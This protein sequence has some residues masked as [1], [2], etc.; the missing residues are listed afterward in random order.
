[1]GELFFLPAL[2]GSPWCQVV[3][4]F[5]D[6]WSPLLV[7]I[8]WVRCHV[9]RGSFGTFLCLRNVLCF[10][11]ILSSQCTETHRIYTGNQCCVPPLE[12]TEDIYKFVYRDELNTCSKTF[13]YIY[14]IQLAD[15]VIW[16][17]SQCLN[18]RIFTFNW[19]TRH[20]LELLE[21]LPEKTCPRPVVYVPLCSDSVRCSV[22]VWFWGA[23]CC[24]PKICIRTCIHI[25]IETKNSISRQLNQAFDASSWPW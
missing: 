20:S 1:M 21:D 2:G 22:C 12:S 7:L 18:L 10:L 24:S 8:H 17:G 16:A 25:T 15:H 6:I 3:Q 13:S 11:S 4:V 14:P 19:Q 9:K 23:F 5:V